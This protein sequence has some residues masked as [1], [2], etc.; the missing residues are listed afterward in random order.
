MALGDQ[1]AERLQTGGTPTSFG[2]SLTS[3]TGGSDGLSMRPARGASGPRPPPTPH[4]C[5]A[6]FV[7][8]RGPFTSVRSPVVGGALTCRAATTKTGKTRKLPVLPAL[9]EGLTAFRAAWEQEHSHPPAPTEAL[10]QA[11]GSITSPD[12]S[13]RR[14]GPAPEMY[15]PAPGGGQQPRFPSLPGSSG[16]WPG[17]PLHVVQKLSGYPSLGS[18]SDY[19]AATDAEVLAAI[20]GADPWIHFQDCTQKAKYKRGGRGLKGG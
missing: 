16:R 12:P 1:L 2:R 15:P 9:R 8:G 13:G 19:L 4:R 6:G 17:F 7:A 3:A 11:A 18:L 10:F 5:A 14:D 20:G